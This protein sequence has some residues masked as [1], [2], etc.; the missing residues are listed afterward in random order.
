MFF[1]PRKARKDQPYIHAKTY[2]H[3]LSYWIISWRADKSSI[4]GE[5]RERKKYHT[6]SAATGN[7]DAQQTGS[8]N[9]A[10]GTKP[11]GR[12]RFPPGQI[13]G[14]HT[15]K[16]RIAK[17][18]AGAPAIKRVVVQ[19]VLPLFNEK[20]EPQ[21]GKEENSM[22]E[23]METVIDRKNTEEAAEILCFVQGLEEENQNDFFQFLQGVKYGLN[24][25][26]KKSEAAK[27]A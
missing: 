27:L 18:A 19:Q 7:S 9:G 21:C 13:G 24:L 6:R 3:P 4:A 17:G 1:H 14:S 23:R 10:A 11:A 12:V 15:H 25:A 26:K 20:R 5:K 22:A 8:R 16:I 2:S